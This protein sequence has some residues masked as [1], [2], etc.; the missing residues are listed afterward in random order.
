MLPQIGS[1]ALRLCKRLGAECSTLPGKIQ[2][3]SSLSFSPCLRVSVPLWLY[4][5]VIVVVFVAIL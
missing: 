4:F 5:F 3:L 1:W 2:A